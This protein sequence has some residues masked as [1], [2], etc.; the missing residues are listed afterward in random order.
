[1]EMTAIGGTIACLYFHGGSFCRRVWLPKQ[2]I[3]EIFFGLPLPASIFSTVRLA[4][5][6]T[7]SPPFSFWSLEA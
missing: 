6:S 1:M 5:L 2:V 4:Y 3:L 7:F